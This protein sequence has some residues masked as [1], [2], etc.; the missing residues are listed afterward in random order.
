MVRKQFSYLT[1]EWHGCNL[2]VSYCAIIY[3]DTVVSGKHA[4]SNLGAKVNCDLE[5]SRK[6]RSCHDLRYYH[7]SARNEENEVLNYAVT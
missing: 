4:S 5:K 6:K 2:W 7:F 1:T 3:I